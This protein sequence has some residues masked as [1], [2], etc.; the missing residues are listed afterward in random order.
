MNTDT[1]VLVEVNN[2]W[3]LY[4]KFVANENISMNIEEGE[5]VALLGPNGAGKTTLVKQLYGELNPNKGEIRV[6]GSKPTDRGIKK[7]MGVVPQECEPY[8]DLTVWDN[9]YYMARIKGVDRERAKERTKELLEQLELSDK[10]KTLGRD[11]SGGLKRRLL[12]SMALVNDPKLIILDEPTTGLDP[13]ARREVWDILLKLRKEGKSILLTTHY[14]EEAE[15]LA[16]RIYFIYRRILVEGTPSE[17]KDKF[18]N[19]YDVIDYST[20]NVYRVKG[21]DEVKRII[22]QLNGKFEVKA[23][24]LEDVYLEV[25][26]SVQGVH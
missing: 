9:I 8:G 23:P 18:A 14:L 25:I 21:E 24:S 20:G 13:Q 2:V 11:L 7:H 16:N 22:Q 6:L 15:R 4:G 3:K 19:W 1:F 17:V 10:G 26:K 12:I 5:I